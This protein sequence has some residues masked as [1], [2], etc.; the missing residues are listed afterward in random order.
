MNKS[1][2]DFSPTDNV[3]AKTRPTKVRATKDI[4]NR[5]NNSRENYGLQ[6]ERKTVSHRRDHK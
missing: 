4:G 6:W 2:E 5:L 3:I 1:V